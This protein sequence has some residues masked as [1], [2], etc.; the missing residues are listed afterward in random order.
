MYHVSAQGVDKHMINVHYY[1]KNCL[2]VHRS[3]FNACFSFR[4]ILYKKYKKTDIKNNNVPFMPNKA[5][6]PTSSSSWWMELQRTKSNHKVNALLAA[7]LRET[8]LARESTIHVHSRAGEEQQQS[9]KEDSVE[10]T[11]QSVSPI[12]ANL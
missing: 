6:I 3:V 5:F 7:H 8:S 2:L 11:C 9:R 10:N 1:K 12:A 4:N